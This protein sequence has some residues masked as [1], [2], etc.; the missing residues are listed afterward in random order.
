M[1]NPFTLVLM[2]LC[3]WSQILLAAETHDKIFDTHI[4]YKWDQAEITSPQQAIHILE[5]AGIRK[6]VVI[7]KPAPMALELYQLAPQR[8]IPI[9]GPYGYT[10][11]KL[12]WQFRTSLIEEAR[13]GLASGQ[14]KGIGELHLIGGM[15]MHWRRSKVFVALLDL[16]KQ[17]QVPLLVHT[18]YYS[19]RPTLEICQQNPQNRFIFAHAGAILKP[20]QI[21][22]ILLTCP[23]VMMDLS[24][25]DPW[26]YVENPITNEKGKLLQDWETLVLKHAERFFVG[27]DPVWPVDRGIN[28]DEPDSGWEHL[29]K[30]IAFHRRWAEFLPAEIREKILWSNAAKWFESPLPKK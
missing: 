15:A 9:Y 4:H 10:D 7:G 23:N 21:E 25:R 11:D 13:Q 29:S 1:P 5:Q 6:A 24:A 22:K 19:T 12:T 28:W 27:S 8:I 17:Y 30:Y 14:Y 20:K 26:R 18:E 3:C 16:A 2:T